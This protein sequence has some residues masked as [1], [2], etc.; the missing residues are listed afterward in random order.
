MTESR[1]EK[2][3]TVNIDWGKTPGHPDVWGINHLSSC[4]HISIDRA[5][6]ST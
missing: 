6:W 2:E 3:D 4:K 5:V 1:T